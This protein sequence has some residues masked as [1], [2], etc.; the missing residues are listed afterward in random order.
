[1]SRCLENQPSSTLHHFGQERDTPTRLSAVLM[2][3]ILKT[4]VSYSTFRGNCE[5]LE[6]DRWREE[7]ERG[8][9]RSLCLVYSLQSCVVTKRRR[10][11]GENCSRRPCECVFPSL[12]PPASL[13]ADCHGSCALCLTS[14]LRVRG[15][16]VLS[17]AANVSR[18]WIP[19][20]HTARL[21]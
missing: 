10:G 2:I 16:S 21:K 14:E 15:I 20:L 19:C 12:Q 17:N 7:H 6:A 1:M 11:R 3:L 5:N 4:Q 13:C 8:H 18:V 9:I